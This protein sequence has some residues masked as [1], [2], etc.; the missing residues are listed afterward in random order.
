MNQPNILFIILDCLRADR[1]ERAAPGSFFGRLREWGTYFSQAVTTIATTTPS[2][3][4]MLTGRY[5]FEH[6]IVSLTGY[7]LREGCPSLPDL[8]AAAGYDTLAFV[9]GP[10][11]P[12]TGLER[13]FRTYRYRHESDYFQSEVRRE[14]IGAIN[15]AR[16]PW[17]ALLH[18]WEPHEPVYEH[19]SLLRRALRRLA[20]QRPLPPAEADRRYAARYDRGVPIVEEALADLTRRVRDIG[21]VV[22]LADHGERLTEEVSPDDAE[23]CRWTPRH[24]FNVHDYLL[25]IP[26]LLAGDGVPARRVGC[27]VGTVDL[28]PTL[29]VAAGVPVPEGL[30]GEALLGNGPPREGAGSPRDLYC[31]ASG[32]ILN[33]RQDWLEGIRDGRFKYVWE[34]Y[35]S[36]P[37]EYLFDLAAD[38][39]E[40]HNLAAAKPELARDMKRRLEQMKGEGAAQGET[41]SEA[42]DLAMRAKLED[43][44]Y[45]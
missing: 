4:T 5:P 13:G 21:L 34:P 20:P 45:I 24:G 12:E 2:V 41:M 31:T 23:R 16:R 22:V 29:A 8:L 18:L 26:L 43:L 35:S 19:P 42:E 28:L 25:H 1:F 17:F 39:A 6:G 38:P 30:W 37:R 36:R 10:L 7:K 32:I 33:D 3:A 44:G 27:Q 11:L 9:T 40:R 15:G 14:I